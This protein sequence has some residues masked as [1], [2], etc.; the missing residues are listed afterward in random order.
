[1]TNS[2]DSANAGGRQSA[3]H[4]MT[5]LPGHMLAKEFGKVYVREDDDFKHVEFTVW[6]KQ[7]SGSMAEGWRTGLAID[8]S[9]SMKDWF[10]KILLPTEKDIT[11]EVWQ[12]WSDKK[13][14][15]D[16]VED[17]QK[18]HFMKSDAVENAVQR[19]LYKYT[20]NIVEP[21]VRDFINYLGTELD[22]EG[23]ALVAYWAC[24]DGSEFESLGEISCKDSQKKS[25]TGPEKAKF[26]DETN[27]LPILKHFCQEFESAK[28]AML[29]FITDGKLNDLEEVKLFTIDLAKRVESKD[30]NPV[31]CVLIGVGNEID[32]EQIEELD[33]L[34]T[35][36][37]ID[38]WDHKIAKEMRELSEIMVELV[39]DVTVSTHASTVYDDQGNVV[40]KFSDGLPSS[41]SFTMP[42]S[43]KYF[44]LEVGEH[45]VRQEV[46]TS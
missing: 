4:E 27:L 46:E 23:K 31:K 12:E 26:G 36:T 19:G 41:V 17:G 8:A 21:L 29:V 1:M 37:E 18:R 5:A 2:V 10:G 16:G 44:E 45:K 43:S 35:G 40:K 34:E 14:V 30:R 9:A 24:G 33:D 32:V 13:W 42:S 22:A 6:T 20:E 3:R 28:N 25:I 38:I 7:L 11:T 15:W 39:E